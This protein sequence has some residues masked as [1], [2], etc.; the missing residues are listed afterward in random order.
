MHGPGAGRGVVGVREHVHRRTGKVT[1][2]NIFWAFLKG[3][4]EIL[5]LQERIV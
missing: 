3:R 1:P 2:K 4:L 5:Q